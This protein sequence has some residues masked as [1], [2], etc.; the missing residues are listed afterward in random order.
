LEAFNAGADAC[1][2]AS[3]FHYKELVIKDLKKYLS[4]KGFP[5]RL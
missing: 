5:I 1:L 2:A 3:L 4:K